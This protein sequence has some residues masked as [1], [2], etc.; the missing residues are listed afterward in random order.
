MSYIKRWN[1]KEVARAAGVSTQTISRVINNRPDVSH[2]TRIN[3]QEI[4]HKLGYQP[5]ALARSLIRRRSDTLGVVTAGLRFNGPSRTL[6]GITSRADELGYALLL[7]EMPRFDIDHIEPLLQTLIARPVDGIIWAVPEV[8][9]NRTWLQQGL[10]SINIPIV[11]LNMESRPGLSIVNYD[12]FQGAWQA[13]EHLLQ[14]GYRH[15][16]HITGPLDW[17]ESRQRRAGWQQALATAG[18]EVQDTHV[19]EGDWSAA[20][21]RDALPRLQRQYPEMDAVFASNDQMALGVINLAV[22]QGLT[23]PTALGVTGFD[24]LVETA[25]YSPGLTTIFQD[26]YL[27]GCTAVDQVAQA[28]EHLQ[29]EGAPYTPQTVVLQPE[30][31]VRKSSL[32]HM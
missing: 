25:H 3:V 26:Q 21:V 1:I 16:G 22:E 24:G 18:I 19:V 12:N 30:L 2:E 31:V 9:G 10:A 29:N 11:F 32:R 14:Q 23:I 17:W 7:K 8:G 28:I 4:I 15:I 13:T 6:S 5:S 27:L 20:S